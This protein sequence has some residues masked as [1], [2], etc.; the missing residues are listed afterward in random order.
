VGSNKGC[1]D[2][3]P[4]VDKA[5]S[6]LKFASGKIELL[7]K[8]LF[9]INEVVTLL[10]ENPTVRIVINGHTDNTGSKSIN[11][12]LSLQRAKVVQ[13]FIL[14]KGIDPNRVSIKGYA[15]TKPISDNGTLKGRAENRRTDI[16]VLYN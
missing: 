7:K 10:K 13:R 2:L 8:Q 5:T 16:T 11:E 14:S 3:Q 1:I 6:N 9:P 4:L 12:K 15:E